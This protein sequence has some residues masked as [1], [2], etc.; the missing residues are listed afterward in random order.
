MK[1]TLF[2]LLLITSIGLISCRKTTNSPNITQYDQTQIQNYISAN[3]LTGMKRDESNG[4]T[5]G[6]YY[7]ILSQGA[8]STPMQYSDSVSFVLSVKSFDGK[9]INTDT[10][11]LA[12]FSGLLGH[13]SLGGNIIGFTKGLQY[14]IYNLVKYKGTRARILVPSRV[15]YGVNGVGSG[16]SSNTN[17][18]V[19]GNQCLD[20][21]VNVV[22]N[23]DYIDNKTPGYD[24]YVINDYAKRNNIPISTYTHVTSGRGRGLYY[25]ITTPG[26]GTD[27]LSDASAF[28]ATYIGKWLNGA[29]F[30]GTAIDVGTAGTT[31]LTSFDSLGSLIVGVQEALTGQKVGSTVA[32]LI[33]S[34]L[35]YGKTGTTGTGSNVCLYYEFTIG[36]ITNP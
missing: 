14:A 12:H 2:T 19:A 16:S 25:K 26:T 21:Y 29:T 4:D 32:M 1:Q 18:R 15:A 30:A 6:I 33:P 22:S 34:R 3:G 7:Q 35:A 24:D 20:Y 10:L 27:I 28:T 5:S 31:T 11:N 13:V 17:S 9:Y 36:T 23:L 8:T